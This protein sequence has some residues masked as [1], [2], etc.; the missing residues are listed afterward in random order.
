MTQ[1]EAQHLFACTALSAPLFAG[2]WRAADV[3]GDDMLSTRE[4]ALFMHLLRLAQKGVP[5][6]AKLLPEHAAALLGL[7]TGP[8]AAQT[9]R[10]DLPMLSGA[11]RPDGGSRPPSPH[12]QHDTASITTGCA[13]VVDD[14]SDGES[15]VVFAGDVAP[16]YRG[17]QQ[18]S[19]RGTAADALH[20][21]PA[22]PSAAADAAKGSG[23]AGE[24]QFVASFGHP[25]AAVQQGSQC[26]LE[27]AGHHAQLA[28][29]IH[30]AAV[31]YGRLLDRPFFSVSVSGAGQFFFWG[32]GGETVVVS[33]YA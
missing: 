25:A 17:V 30:T 14:E 13:S 8:L 19:V 2:L 12:H 24:T 32:G 22:A 3:D 27:D 29:D 23:A 31:R 21:V 4:F 28:V 16:G 11:L 20:L 7:P 5:L 33:C 18:V 6:P 9:M 26:W 1:M 10:V 15:D